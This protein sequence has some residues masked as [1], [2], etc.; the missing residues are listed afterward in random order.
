MAHEGCLLG[1]GNTNMY[2]CE[3]LTPCI[4]ILPALWSQTTIRHPSCSVSA[5]M[6]FPRKLSEDVML[7]EA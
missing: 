7:D 5:Y 6:N 4:R 3:S 1:L 2:M